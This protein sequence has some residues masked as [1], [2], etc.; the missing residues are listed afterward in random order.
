ME[1]PSVRPRGR[2]GGTLQPTQG[3]ASGSLLS[4]SSTLLARSE[5][6]THLTDQF[7]IFRI[8][9]IPFHTIGVTQLLF[10]VFSFVQ[11]KAPILFVAAEKDALC[12]ADSV[13]AAVAIAP[14]AKLSI[15]DV[16]HFEIYLGD[17][18][19]VTSVCFV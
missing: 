8:G 3:F 9:H 15:H 10:R 19:Q 2:N 12:P 14:N 16:T 7:P 17:T 11:V 5:V 1:E 6:L 4:L 13:R 18:L